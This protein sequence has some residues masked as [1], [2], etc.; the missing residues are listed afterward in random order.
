MSDKCAQAWSQGISNLFEQT[1]YSA[2]LHHI[3]T[4]V[5]TAFSYYYYILLASTLSLSAC[6]HFGR[7]KSEDG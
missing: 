6:Y 5:L 1:K 4:T 3:L 7:I 2:L